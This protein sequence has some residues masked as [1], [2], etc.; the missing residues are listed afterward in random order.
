MSGYAPFDGL[1]AAAAALA[2]ILSAIVSLIGAASRRRNIA[3]GIAQVQDLC[4][5]TGITDP[6][7]LQDV[8][9]PPDMG[10]VWRTVTLA[11]VTRARRPLGHLISDPVVD[12]ACIAV[13]VASFFS[14][15][16]LVELALIF[17]LMAQVASWI[18][19]ARLPR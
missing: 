9:G 19:A 15:F 10:R 6:R 2:I 12:W 13:A 11:D 18:A 5:L 8:F 7:I 1:T 17:A 16:W 3:M 14:D 4:E